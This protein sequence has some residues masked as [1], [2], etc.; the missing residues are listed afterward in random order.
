MSK[1]IINNNKMNEY[2]GN[3]ALELALNAV[4]ECAKKYGFNAD[5]A[6]EELGLNSNHFVFK[7]TKKDVKES[8]Q[9]K[10]AKPKFPFPYSG[11]YKEE[12]CQGLK[13]NRG[14]YTQCLFLKTKDIES[15]DYCKRCSSQAERNS[16]NKPDCGSI[17]ERQQS[18]FMEFRD[19]KGK[20]P[21]HFVKVMR[22]LQ[23][24][25]EDVIEEAGKFNIKIDEVHFLEPP[26]PAKKGRKPA[27][28][29]KDTQEKKKGRPSNKKEVIVSS[30]T[31]VEGE[32]TDLFSL[33]T[34][35]AAASASATTSASGEEAKEPE[36][37]VVEEAKEPA[38]AVVEEAETGSNDEHFYFIQEPP[39]V[40]EE[41][42]TEEP[43]TEEPVTEEPVIVTEV[44]VKKNSKEKS[45]DKDKE[46]K[47]T[48]G[49]EVKKS[50]KEKTTEKDKESKKTAGKEVKKPSKEK[51]KKEAEEKA[52]KEAEE[53]AKKEAEE[54]AKKEAEAEDEDEDDD[55]DNDLAQKEE[56]EDEDDA[57]ESNM[58][59]PFKFA[60][61]S[62]WINQHD[63]I[64][65]LGSA[66]TD[67][68]PVGKWDKK[69]KSIIFTSTKSEADE[70]SDEESADE[71]ES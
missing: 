16:D 3:I 56:E 21:I 50:S 70:G 66:D 38:Y 47:K 65:S 71:Y 4:K 33:L 36:E 9:I 1:V 49:K 27:T 53:K 31:E 39:A 55:E 19:R 25:K 48:A 2:F 44:I 22:K 30:S 37:A 52:K 64:Y 35:K 29:K 46:S 5:E 69:K 61:I 54:K 59:N 60:G 34:K 7:Q 8:K 11:E 63:I 57:A 18:S 32:V 41:P 14:L 15:S 17:Q 51:A 20:T 23:F 58:M 62:Y 26:P 10:L 28:E 12:C 45:S 40:T 6:I 68:E 67:P 42:V 13:Y 43:V 24:T